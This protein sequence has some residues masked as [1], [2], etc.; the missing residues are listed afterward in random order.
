M[1]AS[2]P[3]ADSD[4]CAW[5]V[6]VKLLEGREDER[7][8][9]HGRVAW[10]VAVLALVAVAAALLVRRPAPR[11]KPGPPPA[12]KAQPGPAA[13]APRVEPSSPARDA[14]GPARPAPAPAATPAALL[15]VDADVPGASV[16]LDRRY[17][18]T[19]PLETSDF[20]PGSH[21]LNVSA[22]GHE[23]YAETI[24]IPAGGRE[25]MVRLREVR[26]DAAVSVVHKHG[27]GSC[28]GRLTATPAGLRY[29]PQDGKDALDVPLSSLEPLQVDYLKKNLR[30]KVRGGK[31]WNFTGDSADELLTF[32]KEVEG[33]RKRL[34]R[35]GDAMI[36][37]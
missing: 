21:R 13:G 4:T 17:L 20:S 6:P 12:S 36:A 24:D 3:L 10:V 34:Q 16:F 2:G 37:G 14:R 25:L 9:G 35:Q 27:V 18:G 11:P 1:N 5:R 26:L 31:T 8:G 23:G 28:P 32:Q 15:R 29:A 7:R 33:A 30:V 22:E 19:T